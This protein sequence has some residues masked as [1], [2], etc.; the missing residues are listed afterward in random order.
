VRFQFLFFQAFNEAGV[1]LVP[2]LAVP[3]TTVELFIVLLDTRSAFDVV[4]TDHLLRRLY[5]IGINDKTWN[6]IHSLHDNIILLVLDINVIVLLF[7]FPTLIVPVLII[8][9]IKFTRSVWLIDNS[10]GTVVRG[11]ARSG[12]RETPASL[13]A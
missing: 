10:G 13:K 2:G 1:S 3:R 11:T 6:I 7:R 12:T 9:W 8:A 4:D 5:Q